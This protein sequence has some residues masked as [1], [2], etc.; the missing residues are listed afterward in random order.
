MLKWKT[1]G[2]FQLKYADT[3]LNDSPSSY[4]P[5]DI[6]FKIPCW[7]ESYRFL[8]ETMSFGISILISKLSDK[9]SVF[10]ND[11]LMKLILSM[12]FQYIMWKSKNNFIEIAL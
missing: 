12:R 8:S 3:I 11:K 6:A 4:G 7:I 1:C 9:S 2:K 5:F 10:T